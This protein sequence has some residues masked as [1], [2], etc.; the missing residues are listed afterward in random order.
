MRLSHVLF[1]CLL[2]LTAGQAGAQVKSFL[3]VPGVQGESTDVG[4]ENWINLTT[5]SVG[6][7]DRAC[8]S[9]VL[10]KALDKSSPLLS[11]AALA[12]GVYPTMTVDVVRVTDGGSNVFLKYTL[13]NVTVASVQATTT[14]T[15][16]ALETVQLVPNTI[17]M[18]YT[19]STGG[20][21]TAVSFT[22]NCL[23]K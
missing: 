22:L 15:L 8:S 18:V 7:A 17:T 23:K 16:P 11:G 13:T 2:A 6:V 5:V 3:L 14:P 9:V 4:H 12:G 10:T 21:G 1:S 19:P 20:T